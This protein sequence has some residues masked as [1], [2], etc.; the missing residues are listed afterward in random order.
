MKEDNPAKGNNPFMT[1]LRYILTAVFT[2]VIAVILAV[3]LGIYLIHTA[4]VR[5]EHAELLELAEMLAAEE[6]AEAAEAAALAAI[7]EREASLFD[8][9]M[10]AIN[11]DYVFWISIEDTTI[12]HPV[13]RGEDNE[14]YLDTSF[15]GEES[16]LGALFMDYRCDEED[17]PHLIIYGHNGAEGDFF[18]N[19]WMFLDWHYTEEHPVIT[20]KEN[21]V[22]TEYEIFDVRQT[23]INDPAYFLDFNEPDS[24][25]EFLERCGAPKSAEQILTLSTCTSGG[26]DDERLVIQAARR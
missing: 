17:N 5:R 9:E 2:T 20:I 22:I 7:A 24:F 1:T 4:A 25:I 26:S 18:G 13:V 14:K 6:A 3:V 10:R 23:D 21:S 8:T 15:S 12:D 16:F 11:P 19:L